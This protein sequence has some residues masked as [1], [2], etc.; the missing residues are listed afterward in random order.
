M[1]FDEVKDRL[2]RSLPP[3]FV[4]AYQTLLDVVGI[5]LDPQVLDSATRF[6]KVLQEH[7]SKKSEAEAVAY[8]HAILTGLGWEELDDLE[9]PVLLDKTVQID[10]SLNEELKRFEKFEHVVYNALRSLGVQFDG[11]QLNRY[12]LA[13]QVVLEKFASSNEADF[14]ECFVSLKNKLG[15]CSHA[16]AFTIAVLER[17]GWG[18]TKILKRFASPNFDLNAA[19]PE[20][21][22]C[23]TVADYYGNM[24]ERDFSSAKVYTSAVHLN[25]R[26]VS[27]HNPVSFTILLLQQNIIKVGDV[28]SIEDG[29]KF[30]IFFQ[31]Y[32][33]R[34]KGFFS[35]T[36]HETVPKTKPASFTTPIKERYTKLIDNFNFSLMFVASEALK[37]KSLDE[38]KS[39]LEDKVVKNEVDAVSDATSLA[40]FL[41]RYCFFSNFSLLEFMMKKLDLKESKPN[42]DQ[43]TKERDNFYSVVLAKDFAAAAII[44]HNILIEHHVEM[45]V[46]VSWNSSETYLAKF[47]DYITKAFKSHSMFI[48]LL[49]ALHHSSLSFVCTIPV[50]DVDAIR[51]EPHAL[52]LLGVQRIIIDNAI[53]YEAASDSCEAGGEIKTQQQDLTPI[54]PVPTPPSDLFPEMKNLKF[55]SDYTDDL[56]KDIDFLLMTATEIELRGV[57]GYLKPLDGRNKIL[58]AFVHECTWVY[59]GKYGKQSVVVGKSA[60]SKGQQGGFDAFAVTNKIMKIFKPKYIIAVGICYGMDP[61]Q[62]QLGDVIV[63]EVIYNIYNFSL[64]EGSIKSRKNEHPQ[65]PVGR[66]LFSLFANSYGFEM[67]HSSDENAEKVEV[68]CGDIASF[69]GKINDLKF[70]NLLRDGCPDTLAGEMEG[71]AIFKA[72]AEQKAEAIVIK[73]VADWA[74][75]NKDKFRSWKDFAS[76]SAATYV[77]YQINKLHATALKSAE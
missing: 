51:A 59:I 30:P 35:S 29:I 5:K 47:Q 14:L 65:L 36:S 45:T 37:T 42:I 75:G 11:Y 27:G 8:A 63:S 54:R 18:R 70:K 76:H 23:L 28:S 74:D 6:K 2:S 62:V 64:Q 44:D 3:Y 17:S 46:V 39:C 67:K 24:S 4:E 26:N 55:D 60:D 77:H 13:V 21:D 34:C 20:V 7:K 53:L 72:A 33:E 56:V 16:V 38:V 66:S 43:L 73:A 31:K 9:N 15:S 19:Y 10:D 41:Q 58:Q 68:Q 49:K 25:H 61:Q 71:A 52:Q 69:P 12:L 40:K 50:W 57:L 32:K 48:A 22:L 1:S